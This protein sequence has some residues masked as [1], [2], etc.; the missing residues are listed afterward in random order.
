MNAKLCLPGY[1]SNPGDLIF[2][3]DSDQDIIFYYHLHERLSKRKTYEVMKKAIIM[4]ITDT[5]LANC[6]KL[7]QNPSDEVLLSISNVYRYSTLYQI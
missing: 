7:D 1:K 6:G 3:M 5:S 4:F 2:T